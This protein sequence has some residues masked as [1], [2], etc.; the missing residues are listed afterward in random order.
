MSFMLFKFLY[1]K[2]QKAIIKEN[3]TIIGFWLTNTSITGIIKSIIASKATGIVFLII[4]FVL[5]PVETRTYHSL[6]IVIK[7]P[8]KE[9][10]KIAILASFHSVPNKKAAILDTE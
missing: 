10:N 8:A 4:K 7:K 5:F 3:I 2:I 6:I 1:V 9:R